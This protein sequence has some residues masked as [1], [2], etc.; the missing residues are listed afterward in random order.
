MTASI[1]I[2][3][4]ILEREEDGN[5]VDLV[6]LGDIKKLAR[7]YIKLHERLEHILLWHSKRK[8]HGNNFSMLGSE[9][10]ALCDLLGAPK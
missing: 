1:D 5:A 7:S 9:Y 2:A 4:N 6:T 10:E 8:L 3:R